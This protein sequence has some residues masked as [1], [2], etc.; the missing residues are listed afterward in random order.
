M[1]LARNFSITRKR[2]LQHLDVLH[3]G[4]IEPT[5]SRQSTTAL[6]ADLPRK[7]SDNPFLNTVIVRFNNSFLVLVSETNQPPFLNCPVEQVMQFT[8][9]CHC[10]PY[11]ARLGR[12]ADKCVRPYTIS[13]SSAA[14]ESAP[15]RPARTQISAHP[16]PA[17]NTLSSSSSSF[18]HRARGNP[19]YSALHAIR[20]VV[21]LP[22]RLPGPTAA[23]CK[24]AAR[25]PRSCSPIASCRSG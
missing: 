19:A 24:A 17:R 8:I 11:H 9:D 14:A 6:P 18:C 4:N 25:R 16:H 21:A 2:P 22:A 23:C 1:M 20:R 10:T 5:P 13:T 12:G 3:A 15:H 7:Q